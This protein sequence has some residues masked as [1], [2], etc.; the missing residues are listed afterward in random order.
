MREKLTRRSRGCIVSW[1]RIS[2]TCCVLLIA[3]TS[4][5]EAE[6]GSLFGCVDPQCRDNIPSFVLRKIIIM[7]LVRSDDDDSA[8][9]ARFVRVRRAWNCVIGDEKRWGAADVIHRV[10]WLFK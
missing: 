7:L 6:R 5:T 1:V 4:I 10:P 2:V 8:V 9:T 3:I